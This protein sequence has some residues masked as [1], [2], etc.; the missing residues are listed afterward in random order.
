[1]KMRLKSKV[2]FD[3]GIEH[4]EGDMFESVPSGDAIVLKVS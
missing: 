4:V 3:A 1:M 2:K